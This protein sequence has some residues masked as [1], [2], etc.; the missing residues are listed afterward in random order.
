MRCRRERTTGRVGIGRFGIW[1]WVFMRALIGLAD[2]AGGL[3]YGLAIKG[4][5]KRHQVAL[6]SSCTKLIL[7]YDKFTVY[8]N[9]EDRQIVGFCRKYLNDQCESRREEESPLPPVRLG[10]SLVGAL[11]N[12]AIDSQRRTRSC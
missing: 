4:D 10:A 7:I 3:L 12:T 11:D 6:D 9:K 1:F 5:F 2:R 8:A